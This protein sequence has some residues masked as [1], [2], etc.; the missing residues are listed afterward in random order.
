MTAAHKINNL[1]TATT[2]ASNAI[3][4]RNRW[5]VTGTP[6]QNRL[7]DLYS[8]LRFIGAYP[9][10]E[11]RTF[12]NH[13]ANLVRQGDASLAQTRM[14]TLLR[15][16]MLRR[17][18]ELPLPKKTELLV[19]LQL[20]A[21]E[22][23][24]YNDAKNRALST[25]DNALS[26]MTTGSSYRNVLQKIETLRQICTIGCYNTNSS[27]TPARSPSR[28]PARGADWDQQEATKAFSQMLAHGLHGTCLRCSTPLLSVPSS[29]NRQS[30][31]YLTQCLRGI[32]W[33]CYV[34]FQRNDIAKGVCDCDPECGIAPVVVSDLPEDF[35]SI[36]SENRLAP[37]Q[38]PTK[39]RALIHDLQKQTPTTKRSAQ[40]C[41]R[42]R[43]H[44]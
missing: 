34:S 8:L 16:M 25:I 38:I 14:R 41:I 21:T 10:D 3:K 4:A 7:S 15:S 9:Y 28:S 13:I 32:C 27:I 40:D 35:S 29:D 39:V 24:Q 18:T 26:L 2:R 11:K 22:T 33:D 37:A 30:S 31:L 20:N 43:T 1:A 12:D 36:V 5:V 42:T 17:C 23:Q 44:N 19:E 6:I